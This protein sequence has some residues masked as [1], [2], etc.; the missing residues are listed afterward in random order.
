M[1][2]TTAAPSA[3]TTRV[4]VRCGKWFV[5]LA[6]IGMIGGHW[7]LL[8]SAA[9]VRMAMDFSKEDSV[10]V[11]LEKTFSG[12]HLCK[13]CKMVRAGKADEKKHDLQKLE[14]KLDFHFLAGTCGL[15]PPRPSR[16]FTPQSE[17]ADF[18]SHAPPLPP[19]RAA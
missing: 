7:T 9:W 11:A 5:V 3:D 19:P 17:G 12:K 18:I 6:L 10:V 14:G 16:H 4:L 13:M 15:F 1:P 8:Q 2:L